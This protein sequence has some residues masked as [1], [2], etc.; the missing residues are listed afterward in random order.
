MNQRFQLNM[1]ISSGFNNLSKV[2]WNRSHQQLELVISL[3]AVD[4]CGPSGLG[5]RFSMNPTGTEKYHGPS[6]HW[7]LLGGG[8][9][10]RFLWVGSPGCPTM[11]APLAE[12]WRASDSVP[13][14][15]RYPGAWR[16]PHMGGAVNRWPMRSLVA[17]EETS[18]WMKGNPVPKYW[19]LLVVNN[20]WQVSHELRSRIMKPR[21]PSHPFRFFFVFLC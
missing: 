10:L 12:E 4:F 13:S 6:T 9:L 19:C 14:W 20:W 1:T 3:F 17:P 16:R 21:Q 8:W 15:Y 7:T 18:K 11:A 5:N 2:N